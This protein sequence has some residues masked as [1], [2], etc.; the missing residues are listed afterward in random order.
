MYVGMN[1]F[2]HF[3]VSICF[4]CAQR[5][6]VPNLGGGH[7]YN[8]MDVKNRRI[9]TVETASK[10]RFSVLEIG[11]DP[12]FHANLYRRLELEQVSEDRVNQVIL[13]CIIY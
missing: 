8:I 3:I 9:V 4:W 7:N 13:K 10:G 12:Y 2:S 1:S 11:P 6:R 5:V